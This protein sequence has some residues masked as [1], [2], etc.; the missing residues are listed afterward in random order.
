MKRENIEGPFPPL[1]L[2]LGEKCPECGASKK[3]PTR[4]GH[5]PDWT[6]YC[7]LCWAPLPGAVYIGPREKVEDGDEEEI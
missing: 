1:I 2:G 4:E 3:Q 5:K 7:P 6:R